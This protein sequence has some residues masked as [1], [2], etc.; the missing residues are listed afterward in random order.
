[1]LIIKKV[2]TILVCIMMFVSLAIPASAL[3][4]TDK[5]ISQSIEYLENGD[6]IVRE[7][8]E[9]LIQPRSSKTGSA[10]ETYR[11]SNCTAI[12]AVKVTG[13]FTYTGSTSSATSS[14][15][16]VSIYNPNASFVSKNASYSGNTA[17]ATGSVKYSGYTVP[18][19]ASVSCDKNGNL[20]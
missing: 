13:T 17:R 12:W 11:N 6:Y 14:S 2:L 8:F 18:L 19:T 3:S 9:P 5:L 16:S 20:Y 15:A 1:M 7:V 4:R 10:V